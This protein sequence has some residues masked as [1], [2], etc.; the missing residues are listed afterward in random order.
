MK[1]ASIIPESTIDYPGRLGPLIFTQGC[2]YRCGFCHN[3]FFV[4][5]DKEGLR[6]EDVGRFVRDIKLKARDRWYTGVCI[7]GGEPTLQKDLEF[8][9]RG[10]KELGL[11][12]KLDTNGSN[13]SALSDLLNKELVDYV[14]M[15]VKAPKKLYNLVAGK[16]INL[17][18]V[19]ESMRII[20]NFPDYEFRTTIVPVERDG[21]ID[22]LGVSEAGEIAKWIVEITGRNNHRYF[23]QKFV[24][25]EGGLMNSNLE[26]FS[27]TPDKL[28]QEIHEK[29]S[30]Y[31]YNS[32]IR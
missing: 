30:K 32:V 15:D 14:A 11:D 6:N 20:Q 8:F 3:P 27:E 26:R 22:W 28:L 5:L 7:S 2:N 25:R 29:A 12:V 31:L 10:L 9:V 16:E 4:S 18:N 24:P 21:K 13:P 17:E 19:E 1:I 23:L